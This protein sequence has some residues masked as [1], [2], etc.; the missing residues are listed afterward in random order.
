[1]ERNDFLLMMEKRI[2]VLNALIN[3]LGQRADMLDKASNDTNNYELINKMMTESGQYLYAKS[4]LEMELDKTY[5]I[6]FTLG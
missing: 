6:Q 2:K 3:D 1:M 5:I 4:L